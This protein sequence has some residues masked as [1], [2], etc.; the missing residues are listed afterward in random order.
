MVSVAFLLEMMPVPVMDKNASSGKSEPA[1][2]IQRRIHPSGV[3]KSAGPDD[4]TT[5]ATEAG[6]GHSWIGARAVR[7]YH[8]PGKPDGR[9]R[10]NGDGATRKRLLRRRL[11]S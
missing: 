7:T 3:G 8:P 5:T 2:R 1:Q 10:G 6:V 4:T 11:R 9:G